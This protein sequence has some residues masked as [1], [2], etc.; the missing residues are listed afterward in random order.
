[1]ARV[2]LKDFSGGIAADGVFSSDRQVADAHG[3]VIDDDRRLRSQ[4]PIDRIQIGGLLTPVTN[5][6]SATLPTPEATRVLHELNTFE[7]S[8]G[9][10]VILT[11]LGLDADGNEVRARHYWAKYPAPQTPGYGAGEDGIMELSW[12]PIGNTFPHYRVVGQQRWKVGDHYRPALLLKAPP[13]KVFSY[14]AV[15]YVFATTD[16]ESLQFIEAQG[17]YPTVGYQ[18][19][20][21]TQNTGTYEPNS[22]AIPRCSHLCMWGDVPVYADIEW[23]PV[24]DTYT[25]PANRGSEAW[26]VDGLNDTT[27]KR[28]GNMLFLGDPQRNGFINPIAPVRVSEE[29]SIITAIVPVDEGLLVFTTKANGLAG[30]VLLHG[31][32]SDYTIYTAAENSEVEKVSTTANVTSAVFWDEQQ[33][34]LFVDESN[35]LYQYRT[36]QLAELTPY[37]SHLP[38]FEQGDPSGSVIASGKHVFLADSN[39][40][41]LWVMRSFDT[42]GAWTRI[43]VA[44]DAM[45]Y[46]SLRSVDGDVLFIAGEEIYSIR[47]STEQT[48]STS[49]QVL[50]GI[51]RAIPNANALVGGGTPGPGRPREPQPV[52]PHS[53]RGTVGGVLV[54]LTFETLPLGEEETFVEKWWERVGMR[55]QR[56]SAKPATLVSIASLATAPGETPAGYT[57]P[58]SE[59][60]PATPLQSIVPGIGP[61]PR[62]SVRGVLQGDVII[63]Q[64]VIWY[65]GGLERL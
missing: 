44:N 57:V 34:V 10:F 40:R 15:T 13:G 54:D 6:A 1:M 14:T 33:S 16:E 42:E 62:M 22:P 2:V 9:S 24:P 43:K 65:S 21:G 19:G 32:A 18:E 12:Q 3:F 61:C 48:A 64:V 29:G 5:D 38:V 8:D 17:P 30:I 41:K 46:D 23:S 36:G 50:G 53:P 27:V 58:V 25:P 28:Y 52:L 51:P 47:M 7:T 45:N 60:V 4:M 39:Q 11:I 37:S 26:Y 35:R 56:G 63:D 31:T 49:V 55:V 20:T 59:A